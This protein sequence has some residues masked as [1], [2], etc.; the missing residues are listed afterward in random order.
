VLRIETRSREQEKTIF[1]KDSEKFGDSKVK[2]DICNRFER[3]VFS[4]L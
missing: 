4:K 1:E 2:L 3:E